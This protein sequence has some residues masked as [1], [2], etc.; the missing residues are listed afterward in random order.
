VAHLRQVH[1]GATEWRAELV[2]S[3]CAA[4][5]AV[6]TLRYHYMLPSAAKL[7]G[8]LHYLAVPRANGE[9]NE[10]GQCLWAARRTEGTGPSSHAATAGAIRASTA[11]NTSKKGVA[12]GS[13]GELR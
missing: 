10:D 1:P 5:Q 3:S 4:R 7:Q 9:S 13:H 11:R 2:D 12:D 8:V 6:G